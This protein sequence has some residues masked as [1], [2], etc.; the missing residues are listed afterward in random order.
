MSR[1]QISPLVGSQEAE[2]KIILSP[3]FNTSIPAVIE[4]I[5]S[6]RACKNGGVIAVSFP[7]EPVAAQR[8]RAGRFG[9]YTPPGYRA[10]KYDLATAIKA[11]QD[12]LQDSGVLADDSQI[13]S[14]SGGKFIDKQNPRLQFHLELKP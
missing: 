7:G 8:P 5:Q 2:A 6:G 4:A 3:D 12:A 14:V 1:K 11:V 9:V 13:D 10:Y